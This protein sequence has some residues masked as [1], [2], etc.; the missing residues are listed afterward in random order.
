MWSC[1]ILEACNSQPHVTFS[2]AN[3]NRPGLILS[4]LLHWHCFVLFLLSIRLSHFLTSTVHIHVTFHTD[5][6]ILGTT[7]T[8]PGPRDWRLL[9]VTPSRLCHWSPDP[10]S[11][12][13]L[14]S[15]REI[16]PDDPFVPDIWC[17]CKTKGPSLTRFPGFFSTRSKLSG[18]ERKFEEFLWRQGL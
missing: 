14:A 15:D 2:F 10:Y 17:Y 16:S 13:A 5:D 7:K 4:R 3:N 12:G 6:Y 11:D 18:S 8:N 9:F 1:E